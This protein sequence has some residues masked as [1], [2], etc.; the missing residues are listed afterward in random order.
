MKPEIASMLVCLMECDA[1]MARVQCESRMC[2]RVWMVCVCVC[3]YSALVPPSGGMRSGSS[4]TCPTGVQQRRGRSQQALGS[5]SSRFTRNDRQ[6]G[7]GVG[8]ASLPFVLSPPVQGMCE[9]QGDSLG[10][11]HSSRESLCCFNSSTC[12]PGLHPSTSAGSRSQASSAAVLTELE[13]AERI[14]GFCVNCT[15]KK[16]THVRLK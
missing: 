8:A 7:Q 9:T 5:T 12:H 16:K 15:C 14:N 1:L 6:R 4:P 11:V 3:S 13:G 10:V 2:V